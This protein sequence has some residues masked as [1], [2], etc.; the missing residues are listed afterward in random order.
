MSSQSS[1]L[2]QPSEFSLAVY[3]IV[4]QIPRGRVMTY[5]QIAGLAGNPRAARQVGQLAHWGPIDLPWQRVVNKAGR[6]AGGYTAG[7]REAQ[8]RDLEKDGL[9]VS[10]DYYVEVETLL[11][12]PPESN[13]KTTTKSHE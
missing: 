9:E 2:S 7:G 10:S 8:R 5:G 13:V 12:W 1:S 6:L 11:W 4:G 3:R